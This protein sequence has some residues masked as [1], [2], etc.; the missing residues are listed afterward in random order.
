MLRP[1]IV[2]VCVLG[3]FPIYIVV[4]NNVNIKALINTQFTFINY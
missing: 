1:F 4:I 3:Y 2:K